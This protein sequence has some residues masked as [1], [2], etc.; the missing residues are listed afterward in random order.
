MSPS[1]SFLLP[2]PGRLLTGLK[3]QRWVLPRPSYSEADCLFRQVFKAKF[4]AQSKKQWLFKDRS[5]TKTQIHQFNTKQEVF[6][7]NSGKRSGSDNT[8]PFEEIR[9]NQRPQAGIRDGENLCVFSPEA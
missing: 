8:P 7:W 5:G 4:N 2:S 3:T 6:S 1:E 9:T